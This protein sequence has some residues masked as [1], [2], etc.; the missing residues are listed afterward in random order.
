MPSEQRERRR[1]RTG[2]GLPTVTLGTQ[3]RNVAGM[4][5]RRLSDQAGMGLA[6][7]KIQSDWL[8]DELGRIKEQVISRDAA[9]TLVAHQKLTYWGADDPKLPPGCAGG[10]PGGRE[11]AGPPPTPT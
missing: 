7:T 8:Y 10:R 11:P 1:R 2:S 4:V 6:M 5:T 9:S 3:T